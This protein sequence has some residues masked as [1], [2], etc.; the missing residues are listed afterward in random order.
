M[1]KKKIFFRFFKRIKLKTL[2]LLAITL[3]SNSFAWFIYSTKVSNSMTAH[4]RSWNVNFEVGGGDYEEEV[5]FKVESVYPGMETVTQEITATNKGESSA[6]I[7]FEVIEA[8]IMGEDLFLDPTVNSTNIIAKLTNDYPFKII[9]SVSNSIISSHGGTEKFVATLSWP[10]ES[11]DDEVDTYWGRRA[12]EFGNTNPD[13]AS[14]NLKIRIS[15][16]QIEE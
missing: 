9:L 8:S 10:Y 4:V 6:N 13:D 12:Y 14:I 3:A 11:G 2:F 16:S 1:K 5:F 15:A 7:K